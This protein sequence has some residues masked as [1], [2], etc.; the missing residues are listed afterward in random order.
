LLSGKKLNLKS[1]FKRAFGETQGTSIGNL[2]RRVWGLDG[3]AYE[4]RDSRS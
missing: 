3:E 4:R 2:L 1:T